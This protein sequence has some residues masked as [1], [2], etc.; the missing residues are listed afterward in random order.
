MKKFGWLAAIVI[1]FSL[2]TQV[3]AAPLFPDVP[4]THWARDAVA[5]LAAK[6]IVEGYPD[7]TF[8][9]D[10][11]ATRWEMAMVVARLLAK[12]EQ[13]HATFATKADLEALKQLVNTLRDEL[14]ALGVRV[15]N[16]EDNLA[17]LTSRVWDLE[18]IRFYGSVDTIFV[19]HG[20]RYT[21]TT[22]PWN[23]LNLAVCESGT[24]T[25]AAAGALVRPPGWTNANLVGTTVNANQTWTSMPVM[26]Y[27][28]GTPLTNGTSFSTKGILGTKLRIS[29]DVAA[30]AEFAAYSFVGDNIVTPYFGVSPS[31]FSNPF[32]SQIG[33]ANQTNNVGPWTRLTLDT[34][35]F[36]HKP[37]GVKVTAGSFD[38]VAFD[39]ITLRNQPNPNYNGPKY[40]PFY[41]FGVTGSTFFLSPMKFEVVM[42]KVNND[43]NLANTA[44]L[45][46]NSF[47][48]GFN[49]DWEFKGGDLRLNFL[50][51]ADDFF[52]GTALTAG[53]Q[54]NPFNWMNP[55][56]YLVANFANVLQRPVQC[57][58]GNDNLPGLI[59][60]Q[61]VNTY[62]ASV[63][64]EFPNNLKFAAEYASSTYRPNL[65]S[66]YSVNGQAA[67]AEV[68]YTCF[69][70]LLDLK[71]DYV[72]VSPQFDPYIIGYPGVIGGRPAL[73]AYNNGAVNG[74]RYMTRHPEPIWYLGQFAYTPGFYQLHDSE[75]YPNNRTGLRFY[76]DYRLPSGDGNIYGRYGRLT[77]LGYSATMVNGG[78]LDRPGFV[79]PFFPGMI[80]GEVTLGRVENYM[81]GLNYKFPTTKLGVNLSFDAYR[82]RRASPL[83]GAAGNN[84][85]VQIGEGIGKI[86]LTYPCN[87]KFLL[88]GGYDFAFLRGVYSSFF[89]N[90]DYTQ[91]LPYLGFDY[92]LSE[93]TDWSL[94]LQSF[95]TTD[96]TNTTLTNR[97]SG[98]NWNGTRLLTEVKITF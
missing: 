94:L 29:S 20:F 90:W 70:N 91:T 45:Y 19:S 85:N 17:K 98:W 16:L 72:A 41:G 78:I 87:D 15:T 3:S 84:N 82:L 55:T 27:F 39:S 18:K 44:N 24:A 71:L 66:S 42:A 59:G 32:T 69:N 26:D 68:A 83:N 33:L 57:T 8:K 43:V 10:R 47:M 22:D 86:G 79:E 34:V 2:V 9:G 11:A 13:E 52:G 92:N 36:T 74:L 93:N 38:K 95:N 23:S 73:L 50:R 61:D 81:L 37:S 30:G 21:G 58:N 62:G 31:Y 54:E 76:V 51:A 77:Q 67:R 48:S 49:L 97:N 40:L 6:G 7:G 63:R 65:N 64:Y 28:T 88:K 5:Q 12:M 35:W 46:Y 25:G 1:I 53:G 89:R 4:A 96:A 60:P 56:G 75:K 14:D 80:G